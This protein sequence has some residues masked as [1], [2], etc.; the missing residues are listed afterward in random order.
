MPGGYS[1]RIPTSAK[2]A[3]ASHDSR[4]FARG[5]ARAA[6]REH[7][8]R[9]ARRAR[10]G[11]ALPGASFLR[12]CAAALQAGADGRR[13]GAPPWRALGA[14]G[15]RR[16]GPGRARRGQARRSRLYRYRDP[17]RRLRR[18]EGVGRRAVFRRQRSVQGFRRIRRASLRYAAGAAAGDQ[19]ADRQRQEARHPR[20]APIRGIPPHEHPRRH[21]RPGRGAGV[22]R[23]RARARSGYAGG[24]QLRRPHAQHHRLPVAAQ[25]RYCE[26]G[27]GLEGRHH[28]LG[29]RRLPMRAR[30]DRR[31]TRAQRRWPG[32]GAQ[33]GGAR[34][35]ALRSEIRLACRSRDL[36]ARSRSHPVPPRR[37]H[38]AGIR[39]A[40]HRRIA[41]CAGRAADSGDGRIRRRA[42]CAH[43]VA[44]IRRGCAR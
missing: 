13:P 38:Q 16:R 26:R 43:R 22:S 24:G 32:T 41:P 3:P 40:A 1:R 18:L 12:L 14:A 37:A 20:L 44:S 35:A 29:T 6:A 11:R 39:A 25:C 33:R 15:R 31:G 36:A 8:V 9:P 21:R 17:G 19:A 5:A 42:R 10:A 23:A 27:R 30:L 34:G 2:R 4:H 7:R 28:G